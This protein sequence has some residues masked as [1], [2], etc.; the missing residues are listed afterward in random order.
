MSKRSGRLHLRTSKAM[1]E[2]DRWKEIVST[3]YRRYAA[4]L[5]FL[6]ISIAGGRL[7]LPIFIVMGLSVNFAFV[8]FASLVVLGALIVRLY[9]YRFANRLNRAFAWPKS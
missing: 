4:S 5:S 9:S 2:V 1:R 8:Q 6:L 7:L 3:R